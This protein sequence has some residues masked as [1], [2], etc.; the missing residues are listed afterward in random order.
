MFGYKTISC[1][2]RCGVL[3]MSSGAPEPAVYVTDRNTDLSIIAR[4][5]PFLLADT[6]PMVRPRVEDGEGSYSIA[7]NYLDQ[8]RLFD[9]KARVSPAL[10]SEVFGS[11]E[12]FKQFVHNGVRS[13]APSIFGDMLTVLDLHKEDPVY[14]PLEGEVDHS[15]LD[16]IWSETKLAF[17]SAVRA[18]GGKYVWVYRGLRGYVP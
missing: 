16:G 9:G 11:I 13:F 2:Y 8:Q 6:I 5:A 14:Q 18:T 7:V 3:D 17:D 4:I 10:R 15:A 1:A 12:E